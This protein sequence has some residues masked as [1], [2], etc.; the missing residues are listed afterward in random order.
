MPGMNTMTHG[1]VLAAVLC[2]APGMAVGG[3]RKDAEITCEP[4]EERLVYDCT[5]TVTKRRS[6]DPVTDAEFTVGADMPSMP[7]AHN[8]RPVQAIPRD[9][10]GLYG[11]RI[12]L[13]MP[14]E[15]AMK[16]DFTKPDRDRVVRKKIFSG[17]V[18]H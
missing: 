11:V 4:T 7:G 15:W 6:G 17:E 2:I 8:V 3:E 18:N 13:E 12:H 5:V 10:P 9:A 1:L 14:G 16:F